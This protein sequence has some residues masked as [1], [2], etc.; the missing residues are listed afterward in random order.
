MNRKILHTLFLATLSFGFAQAVSWGQVPGGGFPGGAIPGGGGGIGVGGGGG[1]MAGG[2]GIGGIQPV[3]ASSQRLDFDGFLVDPT[4]VFRIE[5][6]Q[7]VGVTAETV[8]GFSSLSVDSRSV[9][10][11]GAGRGVGGARGLGGLMGG[12]LG[13][14]LS[15]IQP[16]TQGG[17]LRTQLR[18]AVPVQSGQAGRVGNDLQR[19]IQTNPAVNRFGTAQPIASGRTVVLQ[20]QVE[21]V[22][23][24]RMAHLLMQ[25]EPG[26]SR[27]ENRLQVTGSPPQ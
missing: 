2:G 1:G 15:Q 23:Q 12:G 17:G 11:G 10:A 3:D 9:G 24:Q 25:L 5:R 7:G 21:S 13:G 20:G 4:Q 27:V 26:V 19:R 18:S 22:A 14:G 16:G 8:R 6:G